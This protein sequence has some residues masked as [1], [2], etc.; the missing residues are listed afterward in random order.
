MKTKIPFS[1]RQGD[2]CLLEVAYLGVVPRSLKDITPSA[3]R[4]VLAFGEVT[5]HAHAFYDDSHNV[6][7][8]VADGG[9]RYLHVKALAKIL[10]EEHD[11]T[12]VRPNEYVLP[13]QVEYTPKELTQVAD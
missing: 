1:L 4:V 13:I 6:K 2:V 10:H 7:L 11:P 5:G 9:D 12:P 3:G 8:Y